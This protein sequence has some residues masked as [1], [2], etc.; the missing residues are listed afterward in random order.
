MVS[1]F[2]FGM[3]F[4]SPNEHR[5][6]RYQLSRFAVYISYFIGT[7]GDKRFLFYSDRVKRVPVTVGIARVKNIRRTQLKQEGIV[8]EMH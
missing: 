1:K 3:H 7:N 4:W 6:T 8:F 2:S 5:D